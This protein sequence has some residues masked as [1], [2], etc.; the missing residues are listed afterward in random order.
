MLPINIAG[1]LAGRTIA[2]WQSV[3]PSRPSLPVAWQLYLPELWLDDPAPRQK[4][5]IPKEIVFQTKPQ[6]AMDQIRAALAA[7]RVSSLP[8]PVTVQMASSAE[9]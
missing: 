6:I 9:G 4:A 3:F 5:K 2:R 8:M 7:Q 1:S